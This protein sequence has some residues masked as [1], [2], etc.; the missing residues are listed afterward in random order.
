MGA[1][2]V[3]TFL[4]GGWPDLRGLASALGLEG[5]RLY[6]WE[7]QFTEEGERRRAAHV[8]AMPGGR[9]L[10]VVSTVVVARARENGF[11]AAPSSSP[12]VASPAPITPAAEDPHAIAILKD[13]HERVLTIATRPVPPRLVLALVEPRAWSL[14]LRVVPSPPPSEW[15][16]DPTLL[17]RVAAV[18]GV[19]SRVARVKVAAVDRFAELDP[20]PEHG[21]RF[22]PPTL[23]AILRGSFSLQAVCSVLGDDGYEE[24]GDAWV[25]ETRA[26]REEVRLRDGEIELASVPGELAGIPIAPLSKSTRPPNVG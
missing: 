5:T 1:P 24:D 6:R 23:R 3:T 20:D 2:L 14:G 10:E 22:H 15:A 16:R 11:R 17:P 18:L 26:S 9:P 4:P 19:V 21:D 8:V 12:S 7:E 25:K 13:D